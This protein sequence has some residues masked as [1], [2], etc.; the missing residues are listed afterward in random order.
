[1]RIAEVCVVR[2]A[3]LR[4]RRA[5]PRCTRSRELIPQ[6]VT[7]ALLSFCARSAAVAG[8][9]PSC[10]TCSATVD[11]T[12]CSRETAVLCV[13]FRCNVV[14]GRPGFVG[15]ARAVYD[16]AAC[17]GK[18]RGGGNC[19]MLW[20]GGGEVSQAATFSS[21]IPSSWLSSSVTRMP[22]LNFTP[23]STSATRWWPLNRRQRSWAVVRSL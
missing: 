8:R 10:W 7:G 14:H 2:F 11:P 15:I 12:G 23:S 3:A 1:M 18:N 22:S 19:Q 13:I 6:V 4:L 21:V 5:T 17:V 20:I 16:C 9:S